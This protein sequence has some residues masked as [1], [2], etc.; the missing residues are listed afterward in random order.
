MKKIIEMIKGAIMGIANVIPGLSG[1]TIAVSMGIYEKLIN[2]LSDLLKHPIKALKEVW[3]ILLGIV[4]GIVFSIV[5]ITYMLENYEVPSTM[6]FVGFI[7]GSL[8][9]I[10]REVEHKKI[11]SQDITAFLVMMVVVIVFPLLG[12]FGIGIKE[13]VMNPILLL[14]VGIIAAAT[15]IVPG[16]SGSMMLMIMGY[17][18]KIMSAI[19]DCI[20]SLTEFNIPELFSNVLV[21]VPFGIGVLVG[22]FLMAKLMK[23]F[24]SKYKTT[25]NWAILGLIVASP[26]AIITNM[27]L[28]AA[29]VIELVISVVTFAVGYGLA[30]YLSNLDKKIKKKGE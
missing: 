25:T 19:K 21:L 15:M 18:D 30:Y 16:V 11:K 22:I 6:L 13:A 17:Y 28:A 5:G 23:W 4:I 12:I 7:L 9:L 14:I 10:I 29:T 2:A 27:D 1:G 26:F 3:P 20:F 24:M 8:P